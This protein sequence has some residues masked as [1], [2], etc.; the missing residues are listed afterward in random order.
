QING[1]TSAVLTRLD[2]L[3]DFDPVKICTGYELDGE[4]TT[5]FPGGVAA[6]ERCKPIYE[7]MSGWSSPTASATTIEEL[8]REARE[9]VDRLQELIGCPI[10]VI[11]TGPHRHETIRVRPLIDAVS[12]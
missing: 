8:P 3:D 9:Y 7:E 10:D 11:S 6:L 4:I 12:A 2:V 5:D 1:Y